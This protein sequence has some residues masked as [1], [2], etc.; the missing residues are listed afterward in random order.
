MRFQCCRAAR[1]RSTRGVLTDGSLMFKVCRESFQTHAEILNGPLLLS[2]EF[3]GSGASDH[4]RLQKQLGILRAAP[5][6]AGG[7]GPG[8][9]T[10]EHAGREG[11]S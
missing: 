7:R 10:G 2:P 8:T 11:A 6:P 1:A 3:T 9:P 5:R 4:H